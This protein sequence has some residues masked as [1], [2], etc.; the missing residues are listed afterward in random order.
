MSRILR[1]GTRGSRLALWQTGSVESQL[2]QHGWQTERVII[3]SRGDADQHTPL[4]QFDS[5]GVFTN[6]F[7]TALSGHE[8]D[9]AVHSLKDYPAVVP[10]GIV[11]GT[12]L[13]REDPIDTLV[14]RVPLDHLEEG[15][16]YHIATSSSRRRAQWLKR[17]HGSRIDPIR[18]NVPTRLGKLYESA[19]DGVIFARAGLNRLGVRPPHTIDLGWLVPAPGQGIITAA[20]RDEDRDVLEALRQITDPD[21]A[22][23]ALLERTFLA[24]LGG[25]CEAPIGALATRRN[26]T[27]HF[28]GCVSALDGSTEILVVESADRGRPEDLAKR[29]VEKAIAEG[30]E[31]LLHFQ[32]SKT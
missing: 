6:A 21:A 10:E 3:T 7:D 22:F 24:E 20:C 13:Q 16:G 27:V 17:F 4:D 28:K 8:I 23:C 5:P 14:L 30:A 26:G 18:G 31:S 25:G 9:I 2:Q 29:F 1:I 19:W 32:S 12:F 11:L 15:E